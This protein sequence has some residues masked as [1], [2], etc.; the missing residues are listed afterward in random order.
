V[1]KS[2]VTEPTKAGNSVVSSWNMVELA[3]RQLRDAVFYGGVVEAGKLI[4]FFHMPPPREFVPVELDSTVIFALDGSEVAWSIPVA[5]REV[6]D[7]SQIDFSAATDMMNEFLR[8]VRSQ[9]SLHPSF[10]MLRRPAVQ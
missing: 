5:D 3:E 7:P 9:L 2:I 1:T 6:D 10:V 8:T 4:L